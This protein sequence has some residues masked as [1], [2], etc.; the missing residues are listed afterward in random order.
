M[1]YDHVLSPM[2]SDCISSP[3]GLG[4]N[5]LPVQIPLHGRSTYLA[6]SMQFTLEYML[7][8][9]EG[10]RGMYYVSPSFRGEDAD[11]SHLN[12]FY[13]V[14]C[15]LEGSMDDGMKVMEDFV[16]LV[17]S[18][19][20]KHGNLIRSIAGDTSHISNLLDFARTPGVRLPRV[21]FGEA[22]VICGNDSESWEFVV[23]EAPELG[24]E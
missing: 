11:S 14:E 8:L 4:S 16:V 21:T 2:T 9:K 22:M 1:S 3:I 7:R 13:H 15:E 10:S 23:P 17:G 20:E 19:F 6:D 12:P 18:L 5:S 24:N